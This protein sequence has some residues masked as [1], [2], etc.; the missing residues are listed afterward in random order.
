MKKLIEQSKTILPTPMKKKIVDTTFIISFL[1]EDD[2]AHAAAAETILKEAPAG[3]LILPDMIFAEIILVLESVYKLD[4]KA[5]IEKMESLLLFP[6]FDVDILLLQSAL[7]L[8]NKHSISFIDAYLIGW[9]I[10]EE[11]EDILMFDK[12]QKKIAATLLHPSQ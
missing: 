8:Y 11:C 1:T 5:V 9:H 7:D 10:I 3:S 4:K 2:S 6:A 12:R